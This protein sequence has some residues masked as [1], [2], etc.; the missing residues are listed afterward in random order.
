MW[1]LYKPDNEVLEEALYD[2]FNNL[3]GAKEI[4]VGDYKSKLYN[5]RMYDGDL[6]RFIPYKDYCIEYLNS[7]REL[8][9]PEIIASTEY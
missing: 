2:L 6:N 8:K 9:E 3:E 1:V 7:D 4:I 5:I